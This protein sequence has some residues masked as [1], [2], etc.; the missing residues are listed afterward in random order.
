M[1][2]VHAY[3]TTL[4]YVDHICTKHLPIFWFEESLTAR[5]TVDLVVVNRLGNRSCALTMQAP[6]TK[7]EQP[8]CLPW[9]WRETDIHHKVCVFY[10]GCMWVV[11]KAWGRCDIPRC[12]RQRSPIFWLKHLN[13]TWRV[14]SMVIFIPSDFRNWWPFSGKTLSLHYPNC[15]VDGCDRKNARYFLQ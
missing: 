1:V 15:C 6:G 7:H 2:Y 10:F 14:V 3:I 9:C 4:I 11:N 12:E 13:N 8:T 5:L